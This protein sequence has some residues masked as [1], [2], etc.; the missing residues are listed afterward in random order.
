MRPKRTMALASRSKR[1]ACL[2]FAGQDL[3]VWHCSSQGAQSPEAAAMQF[4]I[5]VQKYKPDVVVFEDMHSA[6]RKGERQKL[7]LKALYNVARNRRV[8][9]YKVRREK[10]HRNRYD[11]AVTLA[12]RFPALK[13]L[14][15]ARPPIWQAEARTLV[16]FEALALAIPVIDERI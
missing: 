3:K 5:W 2:I 1:L 6:R 9:H 4:K 7:I 10:V 12:K 16:L 14:V 15:P 13:H 11:E 8:K